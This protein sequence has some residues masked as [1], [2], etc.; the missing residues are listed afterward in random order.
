MTTA[1]SGHGPLYLDACA[2]TP[3]AA[4]VLEAMASA[5][6]TAWANPSSLHGFGLAAAE[7]LERSRLGIAS[8]L[9]CDPEALVFTSGGTE[10]I[11]TALLG[12]AAPLPSGRLLISAVEHP[13]TLAAAAALERRGWQVAVLPVDRLGRID[14]TALESLLEPPTR[15]VSVIWGQS[16]VG[17]VQPIEAIGRRCRQAGVALHVDAVQV[18]GHRGVAFNRLPIDLLSCAA[19]KLQGP[20]GVGALLVR[21]DLPFVPLIGGGGQ[22]GGR[23]GG[24]EAVALVAGF[25]RALELCDARLAAHGGTDPVAALRDGLLRRLLDLPG[26]RLSG[27]DPLGGPAASDDRLP[28]HISL[29]ISDTAG[30]PLS[31]RRLVPMLWRQGVAASSGS[32]CSSGGGPAP[33]PVLQAMG[34]TQAEAASGLR[35]SLG[36]WLQAAD[37][38]SVPEALMRSRA[39]LAQADGRASSR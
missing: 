36:P 31:G 23:R 5:A 12:A 18:V 14:L 34:L 7:L 26:L 11:H 38:E 19:H 9:G 15:L 10:S 25:A 27:P 33:S 39:A 30:A 8:S 3:P 20:R 28:H 22:E 29:L 6:A 1:A 37:L 17:T 24:T 35:L 13:A 4:A 21:P 2:T 16:E 32:A